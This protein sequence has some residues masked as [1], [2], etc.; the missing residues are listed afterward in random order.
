MV[1]GGR[2]GHLRDE[3]VHLAHGAAVG[4]AHHLPAPQPRQLHVG[5]VHP[6]G[7]ARARLRHLPVVQLDPTHLQQE[8]W[9]SE[10]EGAA[11]CIQNT[12]VIPHGTLG[13]PPVCESIIS[14][15]F[16]PCLAT[17][18]FP[19]LSPGLALQFKLELAVVQVWSSPDARDRLP[20]AKIAV[21]ML[22]TLTTL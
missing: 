2:E 12:V 14:P 10:L 13:C 15:R 21:F 1:A 11:G 8:G 22:S 6:H 9:R 3:V 19:N 18:Q 16:T 4:V 20:L 17:S 7:V 5:Q